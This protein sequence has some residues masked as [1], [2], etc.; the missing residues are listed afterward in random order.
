M[1]VAHGPGVETGAEVRKAPR[2]SERSVAA[3]APG[4]RE[5]GDEGAHARSEELEQAAARPEE[6]AA[7]AG[8]GVEADVAAGV[9]AGKGKWCSGC[10]E[11]WPPAREAM[12][13]PAAAG[14]IVEDRPGE[15]WAAA[16]A[17]AS[18]R[19]FVAASALSSGQ[20]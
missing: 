6:A 7:G 4:R 14:R 16:G 18:C 1:V 19:G 13:S 17:A 5:K 15:A 20:V 12:S 9:A 2:A 11:E 10:K 8:A 3:K